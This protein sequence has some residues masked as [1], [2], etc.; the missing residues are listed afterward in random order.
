MTVRPKIGAPGVIGTPVPAIQHAAAPNDISAPIVTLTFDDGPSTTLTPKLLQILATENIKAAFFVLGQRIEQG[1]A[2][3]IRN[4]SGQGH[5]I[6][7]HSWDHPDLKTLSEAEIEDQLSKTQAL[8]GKL[9]GP[10]KFFRPPYGSQN[11]A[12]KKVAKKLGLTTVL[13]TAD[14]L[15]WKNHTAGWIDT[16]LDAIHPTGRSIVLN[17]DIHKTTVDNVKDFIAA[18]RKRFPKVQFAPLT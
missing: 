17:H 15:D 8:I 11:A 7:N 3:I 13:W 1:G 12:V 6:G 2:E 5:Q 18:I 14:S 10:K 9:S 4:A 16:A